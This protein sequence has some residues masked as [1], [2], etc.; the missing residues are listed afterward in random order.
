MIGI[1][2]VLCPVDL[3]GCSRRALEHAAAIAHGWQ[4]QL[5]VLHV[6]RTLSPFDTAPRLNETAAI[7]DLDR[8]P[9]LEGLRTTLREF[10]TSVAG[11]PGIAIKLAHGPDVCAVIVSEIEAN[12]ADL[13]V[14]GSHGRGGFERF[15]LG[16]TSGKIVRQALCPV[17]IVPPQ[18]PPPADGRF[19]RI[20]CGIDFSPPSIRA[21]RYAIQLASRQG[22]E[23]TVLH[24][25]EMPPELREQQIVAA[26][27]VEAVRA[28]AEAAARHRLAALWPGDAPPP[29]RI[30]ADVVEGRAHRAILE[31]ARRE[32]SD[33]IVLGAQGR[34]A[35]D[36]WLFGSNTQAVLH[37]PPCPV[38]TVRAE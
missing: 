16:S 7:T 15:F 29:V 17:L 5:E 2:R 4:A 38:L 37:D 35:I 9:D 10:V 19:S 20:V 33:L 36:R 24:A 30:V 8:E 25:I 12:Q 28:A 18:A 21:F 23:V 6:H 27:D 34:G 1:R 22:A 13:L 11:H 26:F 14:V 31:T 32:G 3:S